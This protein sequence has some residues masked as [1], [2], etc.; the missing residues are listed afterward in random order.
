MEMK[1]LDF[2]NAVRDFPIISL[3]HIFN[4][5]K[6]PQT[7][8]VQLI[9]WQRKGLVIKLKRGLYI[10]NENDRKVEPS[11]L[12]I[13]NALYSPSY[14]STTYAFGY[15]DLIPER[16]EDVTSITTKKTARFTNPFGTF[17][18]QQRLCWSLYNFDFYPPYRPLL[19]ENSAKI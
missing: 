14:V 5:S 3:N 15:Y 16:V 1:Y 7:L 10:L 2:K 11:R 12:F 4:I 6:N 8:I 17:I 9:G 13:A 19:E 18:Y